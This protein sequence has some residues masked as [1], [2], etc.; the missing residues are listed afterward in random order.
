M[1]KIHIVENVISEEDARTIISEMNN[2]SESNPY[3][4]FYSNRNGGTA[5]PYNKT[6]IGLMKKYGEKTRAIVKSLYDLDHEVYVTKSYSSHWTEGTE[7]GPHIDDQEKEPFIEYSAVVYLN[8]YPEFEGGKLYFPQQNFEYNPVKYSG[9]FFPQKDL[10]YIHG[11][12]KV[13]SG[14]RYTFLF[15][16]SS[17]IQFADPDILGE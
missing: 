7:G 5:L 1:N 17:D 16:Y 11:I 3:P 4:D 14:H 12:S 13:T 15:H 2:P 9:A 6:T 8:E 10:S